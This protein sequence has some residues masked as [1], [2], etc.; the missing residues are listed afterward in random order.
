M[1]GRKFLMLLAVIFTVTAVFYY[2]TTPR[3]NDIDLVGV[4]DGNEVIVSPHK[5]AILE[6]AKGLEPP[7][8]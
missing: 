6:L 4:I 2:F 1:T 3:G 7:T 5:V 8:L